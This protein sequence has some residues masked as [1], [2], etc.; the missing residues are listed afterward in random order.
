MSGIPVVRHAPMGR[1]IQPIPVIL[2]H[3]RC[4]RWKVIVR[5]NVMQDIINLAAAVRHVQVSVRRIYHN[6][7]HAI[8]PARN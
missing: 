4:T 1:Q 6:H 7:V 8:Q 2:R 3:L 5:G